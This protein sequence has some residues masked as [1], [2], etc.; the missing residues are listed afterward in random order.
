[1]RLDNPALG[2]PDSGNL[3]NCIGLPSAGLSLSN[4][5][6]LLGRTAVG[7][8]AAEELTVTGATLANGVLAITGGLTPTSRKTGA[9]NIAVNDLV[10][11][12]SA[13]GTINLGMPITASLVDGD[14]IGIFDMTNSC[15]TNNVTLVCASGATIEGDNAGLTIDVAGAY[16]VLFYD[17]V[18]TNWKMT[19][20][21][22]FGGDVF[23]IAQTAIDGELVV[24]NGTSGNSIKGTNLKMP[25][26]APIA[27]QVLTAV[28][29]SEAEWRTTA[30]NVHLFA[31]AAAYG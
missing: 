31:F 18:S 8:G 16:V 9:Y 20:T 3:A 26:V 1:M 6:R 17:A 22:F 5:A 28:N 10:R 30:A 12:D 7:A 4:T 25:T 29:S 14:R 13:S 19:E 11:V 24:F 23:S 27:D 2:T 21:P 15:A